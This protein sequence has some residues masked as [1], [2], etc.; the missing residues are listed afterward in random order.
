MNCSFLSLI[1]CLGLRFFAGGRGELRVW[2]YPC[3]QEHPVVK[4]WV[5]SQGRLVC[6]ASEMPRGTDGASQ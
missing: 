2:C 3:V 1:I 6:T 5:M 4:G